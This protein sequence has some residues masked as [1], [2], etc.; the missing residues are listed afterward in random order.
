MSNNT[1][2]YAVFGNPIEHSLSPTIHAEFA[3][4]FGKTIDYQKQYVELGSFPKTTS[5][6][7]SGA[8]KGLNITVPFKQEAYTF[9]N[10]LS[11][12]AKA[13][14]AVNTLVLQENKQV[15]GEN[16]DGFGLVN[17]MKE[18]LG[19]SL[20]NASVLVVGA[21][22][23]VRGVLLPL[24]NESPQQVVVV[25]RTL[26]KAQMLAEQFHA[27]GNIQAGRFEDLKNINGGF[28]I[29]INGTSA[30]LGG[31]IPPLDASLITAQTCVYDMVYGKALTPFLKWAK[32]QGAKEVADGLGMLV[33]QAAE[34]FR[35]W[36]GKRPEISPVIELLRAKP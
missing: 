27:N 23:A 17:D 7:F 18:R 8:G 1:D 14:G 22:G 19:W 12:R 24:L 32:D 34:S 33:G 28:D 36:F 3:K 13:A 35:L 26:E 4:Q 15:L 10:V 31:D 2:K 6:F 11:A 20:E 16:T 29:I 21:G 25:N 30:S 5:D 9:A